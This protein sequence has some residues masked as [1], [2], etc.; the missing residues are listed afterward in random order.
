[1]K[2]QG[3]NK[4]PI[5]RNGLRFLPL[6]LF[7]AIIIR[8]GF[9]TAFAQDEN[10]DLWRVRGNAQYGLPPSTG[11]RWHADSL[12]VGATFQRDTTKSFVVWLANYFIPQGSYEGSLYLMIPRQG[13]PDSAI[14]LFRNRC[15]WSAPTS[16]DLTSI[17]P[18]IHH[19]DTVFFMYRSDSANMGG[20]SCGGWFG[21]PNDFGVK[22]TDS[23]F[24]GPNRA[25]G[26][27]W[28]N[29]DR[30][31]S[32]RN[33]SAISILTGR[34]PVVPDSFYSLIQQ[35]FVKYGRRW[36]VAGWV[37][38]DTLPVLPGSG[39]RTDTVE[40]GFEDQFNGT[41]MNF[42]DA[43]FNVRGVF[44]N[45]GVQADLF[46]EK[47]KIVSAA[48]NQDIAKVNIDEDSDITIKVMGVLSTDP[49]TNHFVDVTGIW[50]WQSGSDVFASSFPLPTAP[51]GQWNFS[52]SKPGG[53]ATLVVTTGTGT[54][55]RTAAI[56]LTVTNG[57]PPSSIKRPNPAV[58]RPLAPKLSLIFRNS[59]SFVF[60]LSQSIMH[61][62]LS[63][64][65]Y[66]LSG[67]AIFRI[68]CFDI[69]KPVLLNSSV[70]PGVCCM[71][72][73]ADGKTI[74]QRRLVIAR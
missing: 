64:A 26:E 17:T 39:I 19:L 34:A 15:T 31:Y 72:L 23:L 56:T 47:I 73:C 10:T 67:R 28:H 50:L 46:I 42:D 9:S 52:P 58:Q 25:P 14:F 2:N 38:V 71:R 54:T 74:L 24:T 13:R 29:I 35:K 48:T 7:S 41:A 21:I 8:A 18:A 5:G 69:T 3:E 60:P 4:S 51:L 16:I 65:L 61:I 40:F 57:G 68:N 45:H 12:C 59:Q 43:R 1:V 27:G 30:H 11:G 63:L 53:P 62:N 37:H 66:D 36:S 33:E 20:G 32:L 70:N 22:Q 44:L 55:L 49:D 6:L